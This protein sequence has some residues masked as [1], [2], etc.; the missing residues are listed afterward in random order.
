MDTILKGSMTGIQAA[1]AIRAQSRCSVIYVTGNSDR[2]T[3]D[4]ANVTQPFGLVL[5]PVDERELHAAIEKAIQ[6][7]EKP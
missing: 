5:K 6:R 1:A 7:D 3:V 2:L 4:S